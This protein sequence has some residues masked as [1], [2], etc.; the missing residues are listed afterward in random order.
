[1][2]KCDKCEA[3]VTDDSKFCTNCGATMPEGAPV[4][5]TT[6]VPPVSPSEP[7]VPIGSAPAP[8]PIA[9]KKKIDKK[10]VIAVAIAAVGL[11]IGIGGFVFGIIK[12]NE[13][14]QT[15]SC[16]KENSS[17]EEGNESHAD[18]ETASAGSYDYEQGTKIYFENNTSIVIPTHYKYDTSDGL[19]VSDGAETW[20]AQIRV[21]TGTSSQVINTVDQL[22]QEAQSLGA[23]EIKSGLATESVTKLQYYYITF[24]DPTHNNMAFTYYFF[25]VGNNGIFDNFVTSSTGLLGLCHQTTHTRQL[26]NLVLTSTGS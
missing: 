7:V 24:A 15:K 17:Q 2:K 26:T 4:V 20:Y 8:N 10:T 3:M 6:S 25:E 16:A 14:P 19:I 22:K 5:E 23:Q 13:K 1:M 21:G 12:S 11:I 9:E 18:A